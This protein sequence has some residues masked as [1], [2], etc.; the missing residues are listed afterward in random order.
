VVERSS[1]MHHQKS[2]GTHSVVPAF[3]VTATATATATATE[4]D[5]PRPSPNTDLSEDPSPRLAEAQRL[6]AAATTVEAM[7]H[8]TSCRYLYHAILLTEE[9]RARVIRTHEEAQAGWMARVAGWMGAMGTGIKQ[10]QEG[11][12]KD[13]MEERVHTPKRVAPEPAPT[14]SAPP[15]PTPEAPA[16]PAS[17]PR[18]DPGQ[19]GTATPSPVGQ[20]ATQI[21][22]VEVEVEME[23]P[24]EIRR[25]EQGRDE[26]PIDDHDVDVEGDG[27]GEVRATTPE[28]RDA[29]SNDESEKEVEAKGVDVDVVSPA[30]TEDAR[31]AD[32]LDVDPSS[33]HGG[34]DES[35]R[36][37]EI[38]ARDPTSSTPIDDPYMMVEDPILSPPPASQPSQGVAI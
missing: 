4:T 25:E 33:E 35:D 15:S 26:T 29:C 18:P 36:G 5:I 38:Q 10:Q 8:E 23:K 24:G 31:A 30:V 13:M 28:M 9:E 14:T 6:V 37:E 20:Q 16:T 17:V 7:D 32:A 3:P 12:D 11:G 27:D 21:L 2:A 19:L 34:V 22:P 1:S